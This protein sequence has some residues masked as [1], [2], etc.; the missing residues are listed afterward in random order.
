MSAKTLPVLTP[1]MVSV[2]PPRTRE[3]Q[4][5]LH[6][7]TSLGVS[8]ND[9]FMMTELQLERVFQDNLLKFEVF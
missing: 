7:G 4:K 6:V 5:V 8:T 3:P 1:G 9:V 2:T